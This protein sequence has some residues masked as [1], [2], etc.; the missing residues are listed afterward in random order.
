MRII[1]KNE[2]INDSIYV[3]EDVKKNK[4]ICYVTARMI[5][6]QLILLKWIDN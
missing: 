5:L 2:D 6:K 1:A 3:L 4:D